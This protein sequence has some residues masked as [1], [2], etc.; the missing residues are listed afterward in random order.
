MTMHLV[1]AINKAKIELFGD[2]QWILPCTVHDDAPC[3]SH[4]QGEDRTV[5]QLSVDFKRSYNMHGQ[6]IKAET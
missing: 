4:K 3:Q 6:S 5:W 1:K 2:Y